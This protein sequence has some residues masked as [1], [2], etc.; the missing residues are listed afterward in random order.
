MNQGSM[1]FQ[2]KPENRV[3]IRSGAIARLRD[4][5]QGKPAVFSHTEENKTLLAEA[6]MVERAGA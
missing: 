5:P 3:E 4:T 6:E 1:D 2:K